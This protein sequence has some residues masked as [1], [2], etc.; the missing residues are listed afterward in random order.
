MKQINTYIIEKLHLDKDFESPEH[1]SKYEKIY[2]VHVGDKVMGIKFSK[3]VNMTTYVTLFVCE[4]EDLN[5]D[6]VTIKDIDTNRTINEYTI[7]FEDPYKNPRINNAFAM[8]YKNAQWCA[9]IKQDVAIRLIDRYLNHYK[10]KIKQT[11]FNGS[12]K[13]DVRN[14][15]KYLEK[16]LAKLDD[17]VS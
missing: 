6:I 17:S 7:K 14:R 12:Y 2:D 15:D 13:L 16:I 9:L 10:M 11:W 5:D 4:I 8:H 3:R 1:T